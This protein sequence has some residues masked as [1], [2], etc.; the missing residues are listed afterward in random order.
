MSIQDLCARS[1]TAVDPPPMAILALHFLVLMS[2]DYLGRQG[3]SSQPVHFDISMTPMTLAKGLSNSYENSACCQSTGVPRRH[4]QER[5]DVAEHL[6]FAVA[7]RQPSP[8]RYDTVPLP[9]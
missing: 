6:E 2:R 4:E 8:D 9:R 1:N 5:L 7:R 3:E